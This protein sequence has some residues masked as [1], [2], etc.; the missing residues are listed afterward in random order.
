MA[1]SHPQF[2]LG[3]GAHQEV[4]FCAPAR[5]A[6]V[7]VPARGSVLGRMHENADSDAFGDTHSTG[8]LM[9]F[10]MSCCRGSRPP[11]LLLLLRPQRH[12]GDAADSGRGKFDEINLRQRAC[13]TTGSPPRRE[14]EKSLPTFQNE[15]VS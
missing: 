7:V 8:C 12:F 9:R 13:R 4:P 14:V 11:C 10:S 15:P 2:G 5:V 1:L 3:A 6:T